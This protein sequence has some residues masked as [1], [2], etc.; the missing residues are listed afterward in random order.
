MFEEGTQEMVMHRCSVS[1]WQEGARDSSPERPTFMTAR[2]LEAFLLFIFS[3]NLIPDFPGPV[4]LDS[5]IRLCEG[6]KAGCD[7]L[8]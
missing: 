6:N 5:E 1:V 8:V 2:A 4:L 7:I 3:S